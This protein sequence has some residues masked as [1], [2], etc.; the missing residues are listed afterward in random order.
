MSRSGQKYFSAD[1]I[2]DKFCRILQTD[3][4]VDDM[5]RCSGKY[6]DV[7]TTFVQKLDTTVY[8]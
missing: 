4:W 2:L 7:D 5:Y 6:A 8:R 3:K 1:K